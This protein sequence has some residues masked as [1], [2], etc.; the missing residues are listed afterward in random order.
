MTTI[1]FDG[2]YL[3]ADGRMTRSD[4]IVSANVKKI[5]LISAII[6][7]ERKEVAIFGAGSWN[8]IFTIME[9]MKE[10][11]PFDIDPELMRPHFPGQ[12][13]GCHPHQDVAFVTEDGELYCLDGQCRPAPYEAP[14][15]EGSGFPFAQM[16]L[17]LGQNAV[18]AIRSAIK[19]DTNSGGEI[20]CFDTQEWAWIDPNTL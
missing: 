13:D 12:E 15:A 2:R 4:I 8:G 9:W 19:M 14:F 7:G 20:T 1:A 16:G 5:R 18:Q 3:A 10:N 17:E 6:R 11:D